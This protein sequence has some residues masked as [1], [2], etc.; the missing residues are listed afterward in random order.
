[1]SG[2]GEPLS[3]EVRAILFHTQSTSAR[4]RFL[5]LPYGGVCAPDALPGGVTVGEGAPP[6][7]LRMHPAAAVTSLQNWLDL[8]AGGLEAEPEFRMWLDTGD[9]PLPVHLLRFT[10]VDPPFALAERVGAAFV[11]LTETRGL[12][13]VEMALL[14]EA[15]RVILG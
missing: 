3:T 2:A 15:Y 1:M 12:P 6:G 10:D 11:P 5:R 14:Q 7:N 4:T 13:P 9:G 8:P